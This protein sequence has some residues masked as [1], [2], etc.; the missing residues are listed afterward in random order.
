MTEQITD[1]WTRRG[2]EDQSDGFRP[3]ELRTKELHASCFMC[4]W[5]RWS[6]CEVSFS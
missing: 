5:L 2:V 1:A 6:S 3:E 4:F